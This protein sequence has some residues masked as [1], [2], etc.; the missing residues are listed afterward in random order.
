MIAYKWKIKT[1]IYTISISFIVGGAIGNL[2]DRIF[3]GGVR[4]FLYFEFYPSFPTFN[5]ADSFLCIGIVLMLIYIFFFSSKDFKEK[6][7]NSA[8]D[9][10]NSSDNQDDNLAQK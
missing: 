7:R 3:L 5:V 8:F 4:D 9:I 10:K 6:E 1:S 2:I